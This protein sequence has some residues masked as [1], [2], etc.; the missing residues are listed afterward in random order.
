M[1]TNGAHRCLTSLRYYIRAVSFGHENAVVCKN[2]C[3]ISQFNSVHAYMLF[4]IESWKARK[5]E[6]FL[7]RKQLENN[8]RYPILL[9]R[10]SAMSYQELLTHDPTVHR[11]CIDPVLYTGSNMEPAVW[12]NDGLSN[13]GRDSS[14]HQTLFQNIFLLTPHAVRVSKRASLGWRN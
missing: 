10:K 11:T 12:T 3:E 1:T 14:C 8:P 4:Y 9:F 5:N 13:C 2:C 6:I 7:R